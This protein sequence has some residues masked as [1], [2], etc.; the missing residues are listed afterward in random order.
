MHE[1][2]SRFVVYHADEKHLK[3]LPVTPGDFVSRLCNLQ[4]RAVKLLVR[5]W[6][7][8]TIL[9]RSEIGCHYEFHS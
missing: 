3:L 7:V 6:Q 2:F 1:K 5:M 9:P 8:H 4:A